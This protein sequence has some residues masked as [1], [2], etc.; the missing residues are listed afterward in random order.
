MVLPLSGL[1]ACRRI[2]FPARLL[3]R[4]SVMVAE[5][6][7]LLTKKTKLVLAPEI[8]APVVRVVA[9]TES[10]LV[11]AG[12]VTPRIPATPVAPAG[13]DAPVAPTGPVGPVG[14][15]APVASGVPG[16]PVAPV[17]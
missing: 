4:G 17:G 11:N 10:V 8:V 12:P 5:P 15:V 13:P 9:F 1:V 3:A 16:A 2:C 6:P 14:P 7:A